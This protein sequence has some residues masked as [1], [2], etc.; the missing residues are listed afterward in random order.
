MENNNNFV[1]KN[2]QGELTRNQF[3]IEVTDEDKI[4][5]FYIKPLGNERYEILDNDGSIG[6]LQLDE[7]DHLHC[8]SQGCELD[9]PLLHSIRHQIQIRN[10]N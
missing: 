1:Q 4:K 2:S 10:L 7:S 9:L 5:Y 8:E 3:V 6:T